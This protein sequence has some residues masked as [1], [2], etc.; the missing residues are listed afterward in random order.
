MSS[1]DLNTPTA[2][3]GHNSLPVAAE[4][5]RTIV[6]RIEKLAEEKQAIADDIKEVY[7]E[8]KANGF[9]TKILRIIIALRKI[10]AGTRAEQDALQDLYL[11]ALGMR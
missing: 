11:R 4:Q 6:E 8:A 2:G 9:D 3:I 1:P 7:A 10:D 5:L